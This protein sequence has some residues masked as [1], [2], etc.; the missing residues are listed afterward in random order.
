MWLLVWTFRPC[1]LKGVVNKLMCLCMASAL[2]LL[3]RFPGYYWLIL[4]V[5]LVTAHARAL[6]RIHPGY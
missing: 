6:A 1:H 3:C 2:I 5:I 4:S